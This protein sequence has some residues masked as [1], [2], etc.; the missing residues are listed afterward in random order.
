MPIW[1]R[2]FTYKRIEERFKK[3]NDQVDQQ[4]NVINAETA[5]KKIASAPNVNNLYT[6]S[7]N[8]APKKQ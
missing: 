4:N 7:N 5:M 1:L 3:K 6:T 8:K 2:R